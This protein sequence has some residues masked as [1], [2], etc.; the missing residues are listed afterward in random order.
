MKWELY[1]TEDFE[2]MGME[3]E[4]AEQLDKILDEKINKV[5]SDNKDEMLNIL[6]NDESG[7]YSGIYTVFGKTMDQLMKEI[8][9]AM[10][11]VF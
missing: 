2:K 5:W 9:E 6:L 1:T 7:C 4:T 8:T 3:Q 10:N 11:E